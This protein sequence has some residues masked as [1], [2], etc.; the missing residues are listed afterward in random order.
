MTTST[1]RIVAVVLAFTGTVLAAVA[2][3]TMYWVYVEGTIGFT[4]TE[5]VGLFETCASTS[6]RDGEECQSYSSGDGNDDIICGDHMSNQATKFMKGLQSM[7]ILSASFGFLA[8]VVAVLRNVTRHSSSSG[9]RGCFEAV[10][11]FLGAACAFVTWTVF[12]YF[13]LSWV[14]CGTS[15]CELQKGNATWESFQCGFHYSFAMS[16]AAS[17]LL[18]ASGTFFIIGH[19]RSRGVA[20]TDGMYQ[21]TD[22]I[23]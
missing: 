10:L 1:L 7:S 3:G 4:A 18:G 14:G 23:R 12:V 13:I 15:F 9:P 17:A 2:T 8:F 16:V 11:A 21:D 22:L 6:T 5:R 20:I 19:S